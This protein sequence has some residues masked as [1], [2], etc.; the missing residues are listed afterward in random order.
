VT[1]LTN[2]VDCWV[3]AARESAETVRRPC[4]SHPDYK[5]SCSAKHTPRPLKTYKAVNFSWIFWVIWF[6]PVFSLFM[7]QFSLFQ[8]ISGNYFS[9][10]EL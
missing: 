3:L 4:V 7:I 5:P 1:R 6:M 2:L 8:E 10:F 9:D